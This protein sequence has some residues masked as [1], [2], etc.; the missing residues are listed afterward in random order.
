MSVK[1]F[2]GGT[3]PIVS[4]A[5]FDGTGWSY[6]QPGDHLVVHNPGA[7]AWAWNT[8][9]DAFINFGSTDSQNAATISIGN[10]GV[11]LFDDRLTGPIGVS[12]PQSSTSYGYVS[13]WGQYGVVNLADYSQNAGNINEITTAQG[14]TVYLNQQTVAG[15]RDYV[16]INGGGYLNNYG[17]SN[18]VN[19]ADTVSIPDIGTGVWALNKST[20]TFDNSYVAPTQTVQLNQSNLIVESQ[21]NGQSLFQG[22]ITS[23][24]FTNGMIEFIGQQFNRATYYTGRGLELIN[25]ANNTQQSFAMDMKNPNGSYASVNI[26][27][28]SDGV[29]V[30]PGSV[31]G[32]NG[33][34]LGHYAG[35]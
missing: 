26:W 7:V 17:T 5:W 21:T 10:S 16:Y 9:V 2:V 25:D 32:F 8:N 35:G 4:T 34:L 6:P 19:T 14:S 3:N 30:T 24:D 20:I 22:H 11:Y 33:V 12:D 27:R 28:V 29:V 1:E 13:V 18:L 23:T 31:T 15:N